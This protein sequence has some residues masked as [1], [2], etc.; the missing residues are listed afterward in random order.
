[1]MASGVA[2]AQSSDEIIQGLLGDLAKGD[3]PISDGSDSS[4][5]N[6]EPD[7]EE[8]VKE[9]I[10]RKKKAKKH[11]KSKK[12]KKKKHKRSSRSR[13]RSRSRSESEDDRKRSKKSSKHDEKIRVLEN[14]KRVS[15]PLSPPRLEPHR[16]RDGGDDRWYPGDDR[17]EVHRRAPP[18]PPPDDWVTRDDAELRTVSYRDKRSSRR[19]GDRYHD[20]RSGSRDRRSHH[21]DDRSRIHRDDR[22]RSRSRER[23][24]SRKREED[25][26]WESKWE[27][28]EIQKKADEK[29][30]SQTLGNPFYGTLGSH[31]SLVSALVQLH[32]LAQIKKIH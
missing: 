2:T 12:K 15:R 4:S 19:S 31:Q 32:R 25:P 27:A 29:V 17:R 18:P 11:K 1:M 3:E 28:S 21:R 7:E 24:T 26:F 8:E 13:S 22:S 10:E 23:P 5:S 30:R 14:P 9:R 20:E 6:E 16:S